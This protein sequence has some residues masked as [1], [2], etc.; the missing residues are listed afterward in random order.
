MAVAAVVNDAAVFVV[1]SGCLAVVVVVVPLPI[2][3]QNS[4]DGPPLERTQRDSEFL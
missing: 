3:N 1:V 2:S 4:I